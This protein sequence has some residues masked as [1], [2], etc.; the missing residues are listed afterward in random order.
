MR[1]SKS[2]QARNHFS[3]A[4]L[5]WYDGNA[6]DLPWRTKQYGDCS[7]KKLD[8]YSIWVS[9]IMLQQTTVATVIP[10]FKLFIKTWPTVFE[11]AAA[12]EDTIYA[13]WAGL[14]YYSRAKNLAECAKI[15]VTKHGGQFPKTA[16]ELKLLPGIGLYTSAAIAAIA[17]QEVVTVV[18]ANVE[19]VISR[20]FAIDKPLKKVKSQVYSLAKSLTSK[21]RPGDY[22]QG[23]MD[24]GATICKPRKPL[25]LK[26]PIQ[27]MCLAYARKKTDVIPKKTERKSKLIRYGSAYVATKGSSVVLI[28]RPTNGLLSN[29]LCPPTFGWFNNENETGPPFPANWLQLPQTVTHSFTHFELHLTVYRANLNKVPLEFKAFELSSDLTRSLPTLSKKILKFAIAI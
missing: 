9:E 26:C 18:D 6:R 10:Y 3:D 1:N 13:M 15:I 20:V 25:C 24:L 8:P 22:A 2:I 4:I 7:Q 23:M 12:K 5:N 27:K 11:L 17:F 29:M 14:G 19:R 28:K 21:K 16:D